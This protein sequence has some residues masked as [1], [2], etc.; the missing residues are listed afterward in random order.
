MDALQD[1]LQLRSGD[2][3]LDQK[4]FNSVLKVLKVVKPEKG[5]SA[6]GL[7]LRGG[8][9]IEGA[10]PT[11][12]SSEETHV[13]LEAVRKDFFAWTSTEHVAEVCPLKVTVFAG[14]KR[15]AASASCCKYH[16]YEV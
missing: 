15:L 11:Q 7:Q 9:A 5:T 13:L 2:L 14:D 3:G 1:R 16:L 8:G 10:G 6:K 12:S 4:S